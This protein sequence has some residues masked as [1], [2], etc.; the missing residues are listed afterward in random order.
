MKGGRGQA[1]GRTTATGESRVC[2]ELAGSG[3]CIECQ[4]GQGAARTVRA[5]L[6]GQRAHPANHDDRRT[7]DARRESHDA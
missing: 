2:R 4:A 5:I 6:F 1:C 3:N 7:V